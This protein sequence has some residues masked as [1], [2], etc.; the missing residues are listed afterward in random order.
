MSL[1]QGATEQA[2]SIEELTASIEEIASQTRANAGNAEKAKEIATSAFQNAQVGNQQMGEMLTSM[3]DINEASTNISKIIK[4]IDDIA[5]QTNILAL[6]AAVEAARA[7][8]HG[9]GFAVVAEEVRN[10]A[11]R[12]ADA[13]KET[14]VMIEGSMSKVADGTKIANETASALEAIVKDVSLAADLVGEI[15]VASNEQALGVDQINQGIT[16]ISDV[17]QTTSATAEETAAAS[18]ELSGQS[19]MLK[20]QVATFRLKGVIQKDDQTLNLDVLKML[21]NLQSSTPSKHKETRQIPE[22]TSSAEK[23]SLSDSEFEKY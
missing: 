8:Q 10:L 17:V 7:G 18:E 4:V 23:I 20:T 1:S 16:Q 12:S 13:A 3:R 21:D 22:R 5:F 6:N 11:A 15:A 19:E 2:S 14:T 9:K